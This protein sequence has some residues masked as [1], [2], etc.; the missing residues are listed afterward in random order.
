MRCM[1]TSVGREKQDAQVTRTDD[2]DNK[3]QSIDISC[4]VFGGQLGDSKIV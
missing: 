4:G 1:T 3:T 2:S